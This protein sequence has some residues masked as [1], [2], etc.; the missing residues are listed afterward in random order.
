MTHIRSC[1]VYKFPWHHFLVP[2]SQPPD[3]SRDAGLSQPAFGDHSPEVR[4]KRKKV[5]LVTSGKR[6][7]NVLPLCS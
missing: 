1:T 5:S 4:E 7:R 2:L 3:L 6:Y